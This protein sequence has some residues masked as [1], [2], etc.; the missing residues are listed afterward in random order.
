MGFRTN[1]KGLLF[2]LLDADVEFILVGGLAAAIQGVPNTTF[3]VD[4]VHRRT[5]EN[6]ERI[7]SFLLKVHAKVRNRPGGQILVP[8]S[9][10][11][12]GPGH[13]LLETDKGALDL[14][15]AIEGGKGYDE[16]MSL[17]V[18]VSL[19]E[20]EL[21]VL[22][23]VVLLDLKRLSSHPKDRLSAHLIEQTLRIRD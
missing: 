11:L 10:A 8:D 13:Q 14:L 17:S 21:R 9:A 22:P 7:S 16:L 20:R 5:P 4:V 6:V 15:G 12:L 2:D 18:P 3:D 1:L 23:L 19:G